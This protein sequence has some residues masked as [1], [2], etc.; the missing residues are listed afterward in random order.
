MENYRKNIID[1]N[2]DDENHNLSFTNTISIEPLT[3][4]E[5]NIKR[6]SMT[7]NKTK[8]CKTYLL[9]KR[10]ILNKET[11]C[12]IDSTGHTS[13][14]DINKNLNENNRYIDYKDNDNNLDVQQT[15]NSQIRRD[16]FGSEIK[17]G[18]KQ[19][20]SFADYAKFL[21]AR[22][23]SEE[24]EGAQTTNHKDSLENTDFYIKDDK[25]LRKGK[26]AKKNIVSLKNL[27]KS[28]IENPNKNKYNLVEVIEIQNYKEL[29]KNDYLYPPEED[30]RKSED[31]ETVCCTKICIIY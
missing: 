25:K 12:D 3:T 13:E 20:I 1:T 17:K 28:N 14:K 30:E 4:A 31:Q 2:E 15:D 6:Y 16:I 23:K 22:Y 21:K 8:P 11:I 27:K 10:N 7:P 26:G 29:N 18:G 19:H 5:K 9:L 24:E